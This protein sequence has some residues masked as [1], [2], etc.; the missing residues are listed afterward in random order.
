MINEKPMKILVDLTSLADNFT[1]IE[2][3]ALS[4]TKE[5]QKVQGIELILIFK[6]SIYNAFENEK[7][8]AEMIVLK[9]KSKL[10]F[11]QLTFPFKL[12]KIR[13]DYYLFMAFPEPFFWFKKN[14]INTIHDLSVWDCPKTNKRHMIAYFRVLFRKVALRKGKVLTVSEFS[15]S[16]IQKYLHIPEDRIKVVYSG[17]S[18][19]F[20][21]FNYDDGTNAL[22]CQKYSLP[23]KYILCLSTIEPR[24]NLKLLLDAYAELVHEGKIKIDLVLAGRKGWMMDDIIDNL[25]LDIKKHIHFTGFIDEE[26]LP[27]IY[28]NADL[29]VFPSLYEGFGVPPLESLFMGT[30]VVSSDAASLPE[31]QGEM[32]LYFHSEDKEDLKRVIVRALSMTRSE[33][34]AFITKNIHWLHQYTW[35]SVTEK[36]VDFILGE[37]K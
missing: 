26:H 32:A 24:K 3:F 11:N 9:G 14:T 6:N 25:K 31:I 21:K 1:G 4:V 20:R 13:A 30:M 12:R 17:I 19:T 35:A 8:N 34:Q 2:R 28:R 15:K 16:R 29:F 27:Y 36:I 33:R 23:S 22:V 5:L 10:I 18:D 7:Q 37:E